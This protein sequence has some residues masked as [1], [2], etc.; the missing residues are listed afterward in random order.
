[1]VCEPLIWFVSLSNLFRFE[2]F[3]DD[4]LGD[5]ELVVADVELAWLDDWVV[6]ELKFE[7]AVLFSDPFELM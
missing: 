2:L 5:D 4:A 3:V 6:I 1:M 7:L